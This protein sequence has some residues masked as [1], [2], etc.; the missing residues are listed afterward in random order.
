M[1]DESEMVER[2]ARAMCLGNPD[3]LVSKY[4]VTR[5]DFGGFSGSATGEMEPAW[6]GY[7]IKARAAIAAIREPT[8]TMVEAGRAIDTECHISWQVMIDAA[9]NKG[10]HD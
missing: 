2:V 3:A 4:A 5:D 1:A 8:E 6:C 9:L 10:A 7:V